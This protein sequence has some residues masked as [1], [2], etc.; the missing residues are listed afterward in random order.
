[1]RLPFSVTLALCVLAL[2]AAAAQADQVI[3]TKENA[4]PTP[5]LADLELRQTVSQYG[6]T[7]TFDR[8]ARVG[9]F[10]GGDYYVVGPVTVTAIDPKPRHGAEVAEDELDRREKRLVAQGR[11]PEADRVRNGSMLNPPARREVAYDSG[12]KNWFRPRLS[13]R[14]PIRMKPG[15]SLV[16]TISLKIGE[17][18]KFIYRS[19]G[20]RDHHDNCPTRVAAVLTCL[21]K[22]Q[23]PDA[24]RPSYCD[25]QN[26]IYLARNLRRE[27]LP[28]LARIEGAQAPAFF[29]EVFRKP[30]INTGFFSF[31][32]PM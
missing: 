18:P 8:P 3:Y 28:R 24:F 12:I 29:A 13:A 27:V 31:E 10:V 11:L 23:P 16:S 5:K 14:L 2:G 21:D 7:W 25:T 30:W 19:S 9:Q 20:V 15:D 17:K 22:P 26:R 32:Q 6:I 1:M 4:P